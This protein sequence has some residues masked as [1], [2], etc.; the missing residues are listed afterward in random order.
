MAAER[1]RPGH[2][3]SAGHDGRGL[4]LQL[5]DRRRPA[6]AAP[7]RPASTTSRAPGRPARSLG[8]G[9]TIEGVVVGDYQAPGRVRRLLPPGGDRRRR[10][11]PA[12]VR[13]HLRLRRRLGVASIGRRRPRAGHASPSSSSL[14]EINAVS[15]VQVCSTGNALPTGRRQPAGR[16]TVTDLERFEGMLVDFDQ[17]LTATEVFN[18]GRFGEVSLSGAGRLYTPTAVATPGRAGHAQTDQNNRSRIILDDG[19]NQQNIDPTRYPQGGLS[20]E[21]HPARRRHPAG[22]HRRH[23]LPLLRT[24]GSSP[25]API[26]FTT[27]TRGPPAPPSRSAATSRS[28]RSTSSTSSTATASAAASRPRAAPTRRSSSIARRRRRSARSRRSTPT[29]SGSWRSRTTRRR[30]AP[31]RSSSPA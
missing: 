17:T 27:T 22:P 12:H 21:Q 13:G 23:G 19:N 25:S 7:R 31:S 11:R 16:R 6:S 10:R 20:A 1:D 29:S 8:T 24:T 15:G 5:P 3:R 14:T 2:R 30:T 28:P 9:V 26:S 4:R 18:L